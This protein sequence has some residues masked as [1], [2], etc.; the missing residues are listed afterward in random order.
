MLRINAG[1][2]KTGNIIFEVLKE[3]DFHPK[4]PYSAKMSV[5]REG[6]Q[7]LFRYPGYHKLTPYAPFLNPLQDKEGKRHGI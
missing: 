7:Y 1:S 6:S 2:S 4:L 3:N 5:H